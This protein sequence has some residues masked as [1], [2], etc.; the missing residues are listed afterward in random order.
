MGGLFIE[1]L[2]KKRSESS[3]LLSVVNIVKQR[4]SLKGMRL[5]RD[6]KDIPV[7]AEKPIEVEEVFRPLRLP[8]LR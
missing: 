2:R 1:L 3:D 5:G 4:Y 8:E 7:G 6:V